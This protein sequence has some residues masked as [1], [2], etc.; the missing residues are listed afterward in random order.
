MPCGASYSNRRLNWQH[1]GKPIWIAA[2]WQDIA[3]IVMKICHVDAHKPKNR[4]AEEHQNNEQVDRLPELKWL[5]QAWT[6]RIRVSYL[7]LN[8]LINTGTSRERCS[9]QLGL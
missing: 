9:I 6:G 4:A 8:G 2:L 3:A 7:Q 1:R 5:M